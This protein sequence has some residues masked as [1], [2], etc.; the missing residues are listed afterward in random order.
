M[1]VTFK[2]VLILSVRSGV[3]KRGTEYCALQF[4]DNENV[5]VFNVMAFG[6]SAAAAQTLQPKSHI[7]AISFDLQPARDGGVRL[8]PAW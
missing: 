2:D 8:V 1:L 6:K 5:E 4:L 3:S 7:N